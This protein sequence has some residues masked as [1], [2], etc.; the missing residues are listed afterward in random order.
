LQALVGNQFRTQNKFPLILE[1][2]EKL[3]KC[4]SR[5]LTIVLGW[6]PSHCGISGNEWADTWAKQAIETGTQQHNKVYTSDLLTGAQSDLFD[7]W[8]HRWDASRVNT[9]RYYGNIQP[10]IRYKP[11]FF[12]F[13]NAPKWVTSTICRLRLGHNCTPV[14]LA[15]IRVRDSSLCECGLDEGSLDHIFFNCPR[16]SYS[17]YDVLPKDVPRPIHFHSLLALMDSPL[18][19]ILIK[20]IQVHNIRL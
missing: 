15:K 9:G 5:G 12:K 16:F 17:L 18:I 19:A 20:Y 11:W 7:A 6:I 8:Q 4:E 10:Q 1:I 13:R 2:K 3:L 14:F